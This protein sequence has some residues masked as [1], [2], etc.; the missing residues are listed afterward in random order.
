M[1]EKIPF[2]RT[3]HNSTRTLF[4]AAALWAASQDEANRVLDSLFEYGVNHIDTAA[5]YGDAELRVGPWLKQHRNEFFLA[6]KT[7]KRTY[8]EAKEELHRSLERLQT[9]HID[10]WQM[11]ILVEPDEWETAMGPDGALEAFIEAREQGLTRFLG[12]TGHG[13]NVAQM[14]LKSLARFDFDS[15]LLPYNPTMMQNPQ[16]AADFEELTAVCQQKNVAIQTIKA[17]S[18]GP[19]GDKPK[20]YTTWYQPFSTQAEIDLAVQWVLSRPDVFLNTVGDTT[21]LPMVLAVA[22][23]METAV[24]QAAISEKMKNIDM[25]PLFV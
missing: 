6:T 14:H 5:S 21:L 20:T 9:D 12:V 4:G 19:W 1:I 16:Y 7:E 3:G 17:L 13:V 8:S 2:G 11:H 10:L 23:R 22:S 15:V 25:E 24:S 18:K